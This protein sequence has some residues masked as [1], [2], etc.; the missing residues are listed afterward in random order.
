MN[1][2]QY[3]YDGTFTGLLSCVFVA[4]DRKEFPVSIVG[5]KGQLDLFTEH[6]AIESYQNLAERVWRGIEKVG[7]STTCNH[8]YHAFLSQHIG[9]EIDILEYCRL[10]F[11]KKAPIYADLANP[12]VIQIHKLDRKVL[13]EAHRTLM[14]IRFEQAAD[15]TFFGP[16]APKYDVIPL[17][18]SHFKERFASQQWLIYDTLRSY[19]FYFDGINLEQV[20]IEKPN[21]VP[22][23]GNL[24]AGI[25]SDN[26]NDW[27]ELW[28][29]YFK[30][31]AIKE[32]KNLLVQRNFMP[33]RFW[34]Y[35][36]EKKGF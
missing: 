19:G 4:F 9:V 12:T 24:N 22:E 26:E 3:R 16:F 33:K 27:Q 31:I 7:G 15:G 30:S 34:K 1:P 10:L 20:S 8:I 29:A 2:V 5:P 11:E 13:R 17:V 28:R 6:K 18:I 36:T 32:R 35:L 25:R 14:F 23:T 21:F